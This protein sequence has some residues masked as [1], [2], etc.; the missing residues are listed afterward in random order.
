M[1]TFFCKYT[2]FACKYD[3]NSLQMTRLAGILDSRVSAHLTVGVSASL[4]FRYA[5]CLVPSKVPARVYRGYRRLCPR[6]SVH[7]SLWRFRQ[8][9]YLRYIY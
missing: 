4:I 2:W 8:D 6:S 3:H 9:S 5:V 1:I 7:L